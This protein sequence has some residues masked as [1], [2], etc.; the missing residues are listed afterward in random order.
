[1]RFKLHRG[2][3][4]VALLL[5]ATGTNAATVYV[6]CG[7][8]AGLTSIGAAIKAVQFAGSSTINVSGACHE[9]LV[10]QGLDRLTLNA[11]TAL[12]FRRLGWQAR[13]DLDFGFPGRGH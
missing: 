6:N 4:A 13:R 7:A 11:T 2:V 1:M 9:N 8:K 12:S 5:A 3:L 10:I